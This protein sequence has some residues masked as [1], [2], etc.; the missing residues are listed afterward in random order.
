MEQATEAFAAICFLGIGLSHVAQPQSWVEFFTWLREKGR[1]GMMVE[2]CLSLG[3]GA[4]VV[5]FHNVW[6]GLPIVLTLV[7][8][9]QVVKGFLRL[10]APHLS[11]RVYQ[12]VTPERAWRFRAGGI[13]ALA[14]GALFGYLAVAP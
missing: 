4:L 11:L 14:L 2:G 6:S 7:G 12:G 5:A 1:A 10:A 9:G 13:L 3:F 8:W